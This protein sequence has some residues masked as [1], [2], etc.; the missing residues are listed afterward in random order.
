M[1]TVPPPSGH[2]STLRLECIGCRLEFLVES[3]HDFVHIQK[4]VPY[5]LGSPNR[6]AM[7]RTA[8]SRSCCDGWSALSCSSRS[9]RITSS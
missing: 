6:A 1:L 9:C 3:D 8:A 7:V 4:L 2:R 5:G